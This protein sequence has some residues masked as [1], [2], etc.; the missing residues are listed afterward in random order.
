MDD[1][2]LL[3]ISRAIVYGLTR[4]AL[5]PFMSNAITGSRRFPGSAHQ[6]GLMME[7][8][9]RAGGLDNLKARPPISPPVIQ[10][11]GGST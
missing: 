3:P 5:F 8:G 10:S 9:L 1:D 4:S 6:A 2:V 7:L 11:S